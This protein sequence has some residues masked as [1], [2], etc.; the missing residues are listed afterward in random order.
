MCGWM[1]N[2]IFEPKREVIVWKLFGARG[3]PHSVAKTCGP[4]ACSRC[5]RRRACISSPCIGCTLCVPRLVRRTCKRPVAYKSVIGNDNL[6]SAEVRLLLLQEGFDAELEFG[7]RP[8]LL[9]GLAF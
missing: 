9:K 2:G 5:S 3:P 4:A 1:E 8:Q 6:K 7:I